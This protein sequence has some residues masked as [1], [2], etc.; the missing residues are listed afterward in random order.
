MQSVFSI[1][2]EAVPFYPESYFEPLKLEAM[3]PG[4]SDLPLEIDLGCGDGTFLIALAANEPG[5]NFVGVERLLGRVRR[6]SRRA[7]RIGLTNLRVLRLESYY[8]VRY[9]L[10]EQSVSVF[11][12]M[13]PDPWPKRRHHHKRLIQTEFLDAARLALEPNGELRLT[14]DDLPYYKHMRKTFEAF[15]GLS[16]EPWEPGADYPRTD[17]EQVFRSKGLPIY[18]ALLR[19]QAS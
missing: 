13:F 1:D 2:P 5:R 14:T 15:P 12:V 10:P 11:H 16:E 17:F 4:R 19:N 7:A 18:R 3:F 6:T 8:A 9:L